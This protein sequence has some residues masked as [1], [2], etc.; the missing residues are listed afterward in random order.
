MSQF[1]DFGMAVLS[2]DHPRAPRV[3]KP[4]DLDQVNAERSVAMF[5]ERFG[6]AAGMT[7]VIVGS[8]TVAEVKPLVTRYLG[9][10]P[11]SPRQAQFRDVGVRYPTGAIDRTLQKGL[12][13]QRRHGHLQRRA[14]VLPD[15]GAQAR[16]AHRGAPPAR[17]RP[18]PR[19]AGHVV[20]AQRRQPVLQA[21]RSASTRFG[22]GSPAPPTR[23]H[24]VGRTIDGI[25]SGACRPAGLRPRSSRRSRAPG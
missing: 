3:P 20:F 19:G 1:E 9:G 4:A 14:P 11:S 17:H 6:N 25:I 21:C 22:S 18:D 24:T 12:G 5:R 8:F 23:P 2:K 7:F 13:Q 16:G 15:R 10:L